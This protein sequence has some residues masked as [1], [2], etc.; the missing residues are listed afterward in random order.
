M[1]QFARD[2]GKYIEDKKL[3]VVLV[4]PPNSPVLLPVNG[5][6][7]QD[8][9][10]ETSMQKEKELGG[11]ENMPPPDTVRK[12]LCSLEVLKVLFPFSISLS[13][14]LL[15]ILILLVFQVVNLTFE[16]KT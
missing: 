3:K 15:A 8:T 5:V 2:S 10:Y 1:L 4:S 9:S 11:V 16:L 6:L 12:L 7:K 14:S 13:L